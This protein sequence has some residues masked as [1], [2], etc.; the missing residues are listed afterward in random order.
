VAN[1]LDNARVLFDQ[2]RLP[3]H[4][5]GS[6]E[7]YLCLSPTR[8]R[9]LAQVRL[10]KRSLLNKFAEIEGDQYVQTTDE[11]MRIEVSSSQRPQP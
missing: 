2:V 7:P 5:T 6:P 10:P 1:D 3:R 8:S 11:R 9:G 4:Q